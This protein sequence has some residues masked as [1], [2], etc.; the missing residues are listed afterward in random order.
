MN[1][2]Y[3]VILRINN[4][5]NSWSFRYNDQFCKEKII[6]CFPIREVAEKYIT[7]KER[8]FKNEK[9]I[10]NSENILSRI[11]NF[12]INSSVVDDRISFKKLN[13]NAIYNLL[14]LLRKPSIYQIA[15]YRLHTLD[16]FKTVLK[17]ILDKNEYEKIKSW[18]DL[19]FIYNNIDND[20]KFDLELADKLEFNIEEYPVSLFSEN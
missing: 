18:E 2:I 13:S 17:F 16:Q 11:G 8:L 14:Y 7:E 19:F 9:F 10:S 3:I 4:L 5:D 15:T 12:R 6:K 1:N 20:Y